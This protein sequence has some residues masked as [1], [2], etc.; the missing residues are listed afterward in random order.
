VEAHGPADDAEGA[1]DPATTTAP[2]PQKHLPFTQALFFAAGNCGAG[3]FNGFTS[4]LLPI[5]L[6]GFGASFALV[7]LLTSQRAVEGVVLQPLVG[8]WSDHTWTRLGRRRP[9]IAGFAP[10]CALL[11]ALTAL[12]PQAQGLGHALGLGPRAS[13]LV[14]VSIGTFLFSLSFNLVI[15]PYTALLADITPVHQRGAVNGLFQMAGIAGQI[16]LLI[17]AAYL[18]FGPGL[19]PA[20]SLLCLLTAGAL[21]LGFVPTLLSVREPRV[22]A[23]GSQPARFSVRHY[24]EGLLGRR[25]VQFYFAAQFFLWLGISAVTPFLAF[26]GMRIFELLRSSGSIL[27]L[28]LL[29]S[30]PFFTWPLGALADRIGLKPVFLLGLVLLAGACL[31]ATWVG[32]STLPLLVVLFAVGVGNAAQSAAAYPLLTRLV[33]PERMG[34]YTGLNTSVTSLAAPVAAVVAGVLLDHFGPTGMFPFVAALFL[35]A[36]VPLALLDVAAGEAAVRL[37]A[38]AGAGP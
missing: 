23:S 29:G 1:G 13:S 27:P 11:L 19:S 16:G 20:F 10:L 30:A 22:L 7:G 25:Q 17:F 15:A 21:A 6:R 4:I 18:F 5:Y 12:V 34:L 26:Y 28:V 31:A 37:E 33:L 3:A 2:G 38:G 32:A 24:R 14:L 36:V 35:C 8:A 9:F